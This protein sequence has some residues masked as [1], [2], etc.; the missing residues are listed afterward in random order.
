MVSKVEAMTPRLGDIIEDHCSRCTRLTDH[1][2]VA[3]VN[4]E[5]VKVR[6]RTCQHEHI[7]RHGHGARKRALDRAMDKK[8]AFDAVLAS[9]L[10]TQP[11]A[12]EV[13]APEPSEKPKPKP[14]A[15][16]KPRRK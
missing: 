1:S 6:C 2:I 9:I 7:F 15:G 10:A 8:A 5:I 13:P 16:A 14:R 11:A 3:V 4:G 12:G